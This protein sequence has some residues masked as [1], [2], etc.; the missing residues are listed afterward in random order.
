M[1]TMT[2]GKLARASGIGI[3]TLRF[4]E[5]EKL[6]PEPPRTEAGYRLYP[7]ETTARVRF[8]RRAKTLGFSL[9]EI[10]ELLTLQD[11]NGSRAEVREITG[12][13]LA[14]VEARIRDLERVR[15]V[16]REL[17]DCCSDDGAVQGCPIIRALAGESPLPGEAT[18]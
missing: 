6:V 4:Y 18:P 3:E 17:Q 8:I 15:D 5:R 1:T 11:A 14:E 9:G 7:A 12:A 13:H 10:R 16:L 2:I